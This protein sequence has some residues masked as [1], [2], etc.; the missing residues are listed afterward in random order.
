MS[1]FLLLFLACATT[2]TES[3]PVDTS[4]PPTAE[5]WT[6]FGCYEGRAG[7]DYLE[8]V[9]DYPLVVECRADETLCQPIVDWQVHESGLLV[10]C[11]LD[12]VR[13]KWL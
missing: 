12:E 3:Q 4:R 9:G 11:S 10:S 8:V 6:S 1:L 5:T 7:G 13:I 2:T